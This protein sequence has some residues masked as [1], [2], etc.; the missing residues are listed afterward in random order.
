V[1]WRECR[2]REPWSTRPTNTYFTA[3][4]GGKTYRVIANWTS[5][6][7]RSGAIIWW[8]HDG[9]G[10]NKRWHTKEAAMSWCEQD[11]GT[12]QP[13]RPEKTS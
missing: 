12:M 13:D 9:E 1:K 6:L 4:K 5:T 8:S 7:T 10:N 3:R 2:D 11:A